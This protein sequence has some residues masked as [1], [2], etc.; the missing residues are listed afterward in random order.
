MRDIETSVFNNCIIYGNG[1]NELGLD[2]DLQAS[3]DLVFNNTIVRGEQEVIQPYIDEDYF[4]GN[5]FVN[6]QP[7]FVNFSEG[8]FRLIPDA[9]AIGKGEAI[10][11]LTTDLI[12][13]TYANPPALG[14]LEFMPCW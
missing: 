4:T 6:Q 7:G 3:V 2:F 10:P 1:S 5:V 9:F 13:T 8:D 14:C 12:G 11:G